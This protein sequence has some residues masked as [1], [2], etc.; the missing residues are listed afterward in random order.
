MPV[1]GYQDDGATWPVGVN[2]LS[3]IVEVCEARDHNSR[4]KASR[5]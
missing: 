2:F 5:V 1:F 3:C 4:W